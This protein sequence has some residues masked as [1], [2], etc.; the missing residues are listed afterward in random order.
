MLTTFI[1]LFS[2]FALA[3]LL[4]GTFILAKLAMQQE[5]RAVKVPVRAQNQN[6]RI[7]SNRR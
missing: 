1:S 4:A 5:T 7:H 2:V 6:P 3:A